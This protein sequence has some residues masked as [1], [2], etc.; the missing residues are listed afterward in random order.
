MNIKRFF[1]FFVSSIALICFFPFFIFL[2]I[3]IKLDSPG[4]VLFRQLRVGRN[5]VLF[6]IHK[7]RTMYIDSELRGP[8]IT[9][10][11]DSRVTF[12]GKFLR[13]SK[14]DE[15]P[16]LVDV[17]LGDMSFV[18][19]RP[20]VPCYVKYY[21]RSIRD[22]VLSVRPGITDFASIKFKD[23]NNLL[24]LSEDPLQAYVDH[25]LPLKLKYSTEYVNSRSFFLDLYII[26]YT[27]FDLG[28]GL[29]CRL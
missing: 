15:L 14:I 6:R 3:L 18:G 24:A 11:N 19:P 10:G 20:E 26:I 21:P 17:F 22:L 1:D 8:S 13:K 7:F 16:Q 12:I 2:A 25:V 5:G 27:L 4:P 29:F 28:R 23:E 9:I